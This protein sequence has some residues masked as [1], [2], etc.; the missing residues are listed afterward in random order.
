MKKLLIFLGFAFVACNQQ[1]PAELLLW[2]RQ[3]TE[4]SRQKTAIIIFQL[5]ADCDSFIFNKAQYLADSTRQAAK[6]NAHFKRKK[7]Q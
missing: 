4:A 5:Q 3:V 7:R 2:E 6:S 1:P